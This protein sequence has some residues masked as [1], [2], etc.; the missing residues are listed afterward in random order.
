MLSVYEEG[1]KTGRLSLIS[2]M[3]IVTGVVTDNKVGSPGRR[4]VMV[5]FNCE[6]VSRSITSKLVMC[7]VEGSQLKYPTPVPSLMK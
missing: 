5:R 2:V 6:S 1:S 7:P 3:L 4:A